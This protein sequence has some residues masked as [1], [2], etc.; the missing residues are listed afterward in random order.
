MAYERISEKKVIAQDLGSLIET[1]LL[2]LRKQAQQRNLED[3]SK[4][5]QAVLANNLTLEQQLEYRQDQLKRVGRSDREESRRIRDEISSLKDQIEV[6]A[7]ED[8]YLEQLMQINDG[9]QSIDTTISWLENRMSGTTDLA[10]IK[11]IKE[12]IAE[13]K[14]LRYQQQKTALE[15]QTTFANN[16]KSESVLDTQIT[17][18]NN[19]RTKALRAGNEDY[20]AILDLQ[21]Q[22]LEK[23][24][25][26]SRITNAITAMSTA[27]ITGQSSLGLLNAINSQLENADD[28]TPIYIGGTQYES[29]RSFWESKRGEYLNDRSESGFFSRY[30]YELSNKVIYKNNAGI[31]NNDS[32]K[33]V[34]GWYDYIK[35]RPELADYQD[36]IAQDQQSALKSTADLRATSIINTYATDLD[37]RKAMQSLAQIHDT[38]GIDQSTNYQSIIIKSSQEKESQVREIL[39]TMSSILRNNPSL[40]NEEAMKQAIESGAGAVFSPLEL[41]KNKASDIIGQAGKTAT[42]QQFGEDDKLSADPF[43]ASKEFL[44]SQLTEGGVYKM[45]NSNTV[46]RLENGQVRKFVG[47]WTE[48]EFKKETGKTFKDVQTIGSLTN[49]PIGQDITKQADAIKTGG[50][51]Q[52]SG[53]KF[54]EGGLYKLKGKKTVYKLENNKWRPFV[55]S[56]DEQ[57]FTEV[58]GK[59]FKDVQEI[60]DLGKLQTGSFIKYQ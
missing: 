4:F 35:G 32:L 18:V 26:E 39:D 20:V 16:N 2:L 48:D 55:G 14:S 45:P 22:S 49:L 25:A 9:V 17:R 57:K 7:Y 52:T 33:D 6:K 59:K 3:E 30:Q 19:A 31:L 37:A 42:A 10:I 54:Q 41:A 43:A 28:K 56:W 21:L 34:Q 29:A 15:N 12:N 38:Y 23:T 11:N 40:T 47:S 53:T 8:S 44:K 58:T 46:F 50:T 5:N 36:K 1:N 13:L 24:R 51:Q 27:T 60:S